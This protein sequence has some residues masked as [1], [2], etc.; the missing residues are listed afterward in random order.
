MQSTCVSGRRDRFRSQRKTNLPVKDFKKWIWVIYSIS[1]FVLSLDAERSSVCLFVLLWTQR[2][3]ANCQPDAADCTQH[4]VQ[5]MQAIELGEGCVKDKHASISI[6]MQNSWP[7][8]DLLRSAKSR[9]FISV[10]LTTPLHQG[11][12]LAD[13]ENR[14]RKPWAIGERKDKFKRRK[15]KEN[16][17]HTCQTWRWQS[18][19]HYI[20]LLTVVTLTHHLLVSKY[21]ITSA[22]E[23]DKNRSS[24]TKPEARS[25]LRPSF[26]SL[27]CSKLSTSPQESQPRDGAAESIGQVPFI[28]QIIASRKWTYTDLLG[29]ISDL[30]QTNNNNSSGTFA[31]SCARTIIIRSD[32]SYYLSRLHS[33]CGARS[34]VQCRV[35]IV[36]R[37]PRAFVWTRE[38]Y[39]CLRPVFGG[40]F[41][42]YVSQL[43]SSAIKVS[44]TNGVEP[45]SFNCLL[46]NFNVTRAGGLNVPGDTL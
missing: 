14:W 35:F 29:I 32:R 30:R 22:S 42:L 28:S 39:H 46:R 3:T 12:I 44:Q 7:Q 5:P 34:V 33:D 6:V 19:H 9:T 21:K 27:N 4:C 16:K 20:P 37:R 13:S 23:S 2:I 26:A 41:P 38:N 15:R 18:G 11:I 1:I 36:T 25:S 43:L 8:D 10:H 24:S 31:R 45:Y 17:K 40:F